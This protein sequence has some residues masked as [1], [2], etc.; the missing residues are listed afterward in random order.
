MRKDEAT[1]EPSV[2]SSREWAE[3]NAI[4]WLQR[5]GFGDLIPA[6]ASEHRAAS[7]KGSD[8]MA[9]VK[10]SNQPASQQ[11]VRDLHALTVATD[12]SKSFFFSVAGYT[13][14]AVRWADGA[15]V[16]LLRLLLDAKPVNDAARRWLHPGAGQAVPVEQ[17]G[18][19]DKIVSGTG[20]FRVVQRVQPR[21]EQ[22]AL[23]FTVLLDDDSELDLPIGELVPLH[24]ER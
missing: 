17:L 13:D 12:R 5:R 11:E 8:V 22:K 15:G 1:T 19:G 20:G 4:D 10:F 21:K 2:G 9:R 6:P 18:R 16:V 14:E 7:I 3:A 23:R 24:G